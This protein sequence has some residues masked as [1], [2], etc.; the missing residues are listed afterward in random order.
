MRHA[1]SK[2]LR[3]L[4]RRVHPHLDAGDVELELREVELVRHVHDGEVLLDPDES[5]LRVG[6]ELEAVRLVE[7]RVL[8]ALLEVVAVYGGVRVGV[9]GGRPPVEDLVGG[10]GREVGVDARLDRQGQDPLR[11]AFRVELHLDRLLLV[12]LRLVGLRPLLPRLRVGRRLLLLLRLLLVAL[13]RERRR[14]SLREHRHVDLL[15]RAHVGV[16]LREPVVDRAR[17][18]RDE[19][20]EVLAGGVEDGARGVGKAVAHR[21]GLPVR[22]RVEEEPVEVGGRVLRVGEE[23]RVGRPRVVEHRSRPVQGVARH[24]RLGAGRHVEDEDRHRVVGEAELLRVGRPLRPGVEAGALERDPPRR[25]LAVLGGED[26]PVLAALV[27]EPGDPLAVRRPRRRAVVDGRGVRDVPVVALLAREGHDLAAE[28]E[29]DPRA[30]GRQAAAA[31]PLRSLRPA[32]AQLDE[33]GGDAELQACGR[34]RRRVEQVDVAGLL[35]GDP[36]AT[37]GRA[38]H[39]EIH[40]G[41]QAR[42]GL[43]PAVEGVEVELAVPVGAEDEPAGRPTSGRCRCSVRPAGAPV[44][45]HGSRCRRAGCARSCRPGSA[46]TG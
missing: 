36:A 42:H 1:S 45:R 9:G 3:P 31:D 14:D 8:L 44:R 24:L 20:V 6:A 34:A 37:G 26:E 12:L 35:V 29:S 33:V 4:R 46:S 39:G 2:H 10:T 22:D 43:R 32:P 5:A 23:A 38:H 16:R 19:E 18:G 17:V 25:A 15:H 40:V 28:L 21:V 7:E 11:Q 27:G 13:L 30:R 41:G